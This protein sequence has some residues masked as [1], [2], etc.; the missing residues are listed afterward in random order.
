MT[1]PLI[2]IVEVTQSQASKEITINQA[3]AEM[4]SKVFRALSTTLASQPS[5]PD[6]GD[7]YI[8]P[9]SPTG[10]DWSGN[11]NNV[12]SYT[13]AGWTFFLPF[14]GLSYY[15]VD[16][17]CRVTYDGSQWVK[18]TENPLLSKDV[19]GGSDVTLTP[20]EASND[21]IECTGALTADINLIV[22]D[23]TKILA[24]Y[25]NTTGAYTLTVKTSAGTGIVVAQGMRAMLYC[26]GTNVVRLAA[27][28]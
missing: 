20:Y 25:N 14:T 13:Y 7:M 4:E 23:N 24:I 19:A 10:T 1:T 8:L 28:V 6:D 2:G 15:A 16:L 9:A 17:G 3:M 26:D 18:E 27:D 21:I 22:S 5:S 11:G 12:A